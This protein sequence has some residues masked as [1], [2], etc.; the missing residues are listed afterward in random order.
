M[1]EKNMF[2]PKPI[3]RQKSNHHAKIHAYTII[4][5]IPDEDNEKNFTIVGRLLPEGTLGENIRTQFTG[6]DATCKRPVVGDLYFQTIDCDTGKSGEHGRWNTVENFEKYW[7]PHV[8]TS[9][10]DSIKP[11]FGEADCKITNIDLRPMLPQ[12]DGSQGKAIVTART[13]G[14]T[15]ITE[16]SAETIRRFNPKIG[17]HLINS[18]GGYAFLSP[19]EFTRMVF[20]TFHAQ[21]KQEQQ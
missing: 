6:F 5:I 7:E 14:G 8:H 16:V 3:Y 13:M 15:L 9:A 1:P 20:T 4:E 17:W 19:Q 21:R 18:D 2:P 10:L 11:S 12:K